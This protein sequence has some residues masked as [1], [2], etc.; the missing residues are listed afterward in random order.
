MFDHVHAHIYVHIW[1]FIRSSAA[2]TSP[3]AEGSERPLIVGAGRQTDEGPC[4]TQ[5]QLGIDPAFGDR[6]S[7]RRDLP[8]LKPSSSETVACELNGQY[9]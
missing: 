6:P 5:V 7:V 2:T 9:F 3:Y 4:G 1:I 8:L